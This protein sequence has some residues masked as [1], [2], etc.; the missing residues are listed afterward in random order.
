[1]DFSQLPYEVQFNYLLGLPYQAVIQYCQTNER[2][3]QICQTYQF[4]EQKAQHDFGIRDYV[5]REEP[6][7]SYENLSL[8][9]E[10][11]PGQLLVFLIETNQ[12]ERFRELLSRVELYEVNVDE[13][14]DTDFRIMEDMYD[15]MKVIHDTNNSH[16]FRILVDHIA[17][18]AAT[19]VY[20]QIVLGALFASFIGAH[21]DW[22]LYIRN[23]YS[24][25]NDPGFIHNYYYEMIDGNLQNVLALRPM[26]AN[27]IDPE[28]ELY[29]AILSDNDAMIEYFTR[30]HPQ[31][32]QDPEYVNYLAEEFI[33][34]EDNGA[35]IRRLTQLAPNLIDYER[36]MEI[37]RE[38][39][40]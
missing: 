20:K 22:V 18:T 9:Y 37:V 19:P 21:P 13:N 23:Y 1:M 3:R 34:E 31:L 7:Q 38:D 39:D 12:L 11:E 15:M 5:T 14:N 17:T 27:T 6:S 32:L 24:P 29:N 4:W 8:L 28:A 10:H 30:L 26:L 36:A 33:R 35:A 25:E 16:T 2:T 40:A